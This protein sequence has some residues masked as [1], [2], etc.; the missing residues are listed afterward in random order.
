MVCHMGF[1]EG[2][3]N[4]FP[5]D[6]QRPAGG[7]GTIDHFISALSF[8]VRSTAGSTQIAAL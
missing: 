1:D 3:H 5:I 8:W 7:A 6:L 2:F 4:G